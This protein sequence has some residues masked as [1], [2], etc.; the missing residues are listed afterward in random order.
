MIY[1][2]RVDCLQMFEKNKCKNYFRRR[3]EIRRPENISAWLGWQAFVSDE[4]NIAALK[5]LI[6]GI[7]QI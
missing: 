1:K 4:E 3:A 2:W 7:Y 6:A 5:Q